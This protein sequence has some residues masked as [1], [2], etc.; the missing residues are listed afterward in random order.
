MKVVDEHL[1]IRDIELK[2]GHGL[3]E[4]LIVQAHN[5]LRLLRI[6]KKWE[7]WEHI[8]ENEVYDR[9]EYYVR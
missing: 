3:V 8:L 9:S 7:P 6:M 5:E 4:E 2:I 1:N